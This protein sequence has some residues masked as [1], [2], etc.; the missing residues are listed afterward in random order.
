MCAKETRTEHD[1]PR[2]HMAQRHGEDEATDTKDRQTALRHELR[3]W[4]NCLAERSGN[5]RKHSD[6][7]TT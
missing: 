2:A 4:S 5:T 7:A 1:E 6:S 3:R